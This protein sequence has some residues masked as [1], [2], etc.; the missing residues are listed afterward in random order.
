MVKHRDFQLRTVKDLLENQ[1]AEVVKTQTELL[2]SEAKRQELE[3]ELSET[4]DQV[5][6]SRR[7]FRTMTTPERSI[8]VL[9][10]LVHDVLVDFG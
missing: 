5:S 3:R 4:L 10:V 2:T 7:N 1:R 6:Q 9:F 8:A